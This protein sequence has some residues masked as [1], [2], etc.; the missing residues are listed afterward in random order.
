M[1]P[2]ALPR[3]SEWT[4]CSTALAGVALVLD[5]LACGTG[6]LA[7]KADGDAEPPTLVCAMTMVLPE[8]SPSNADAI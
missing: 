2:K 6:E 1:Q 4:D 8:E 7:V 3:L 5:E